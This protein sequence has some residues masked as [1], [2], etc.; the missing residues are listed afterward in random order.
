[1]PEDEGSPVQS[2]N[3][4]WQFGWC[5]YVEDSNVLLVKGTPIRMESKAA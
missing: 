5:E 3:H 2:G 4:R 1:M